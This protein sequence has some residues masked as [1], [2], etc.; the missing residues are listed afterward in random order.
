MVYRE[1]TNVMKPSNAMET[2][3][4]RKSALSNKHPPSNM[5]CTENLNFPEEVY[6]RFPPTL[7]CKPNSSPILRGERGGGV[8]NIR[9][10]KGGPDKNKFKRNKGV[11]IYC[12]NYHQ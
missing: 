4:A 9:D 7:L 3:F 11:M 1:T 12:R 6:T 10:N 2:V 5:G 8:T